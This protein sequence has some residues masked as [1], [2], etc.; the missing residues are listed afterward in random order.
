MKK[1]NPGVLFNARASICSAQKCPPRSG[2]VQSGSKPSDSRVFP[3]LAVPWYAGLKQNAALTPPREVSLE[4][5]GARR[6]LL[7]HLR[8]QGDQALGQRAMDAHQEPAFNMILTLQ[9]FTDS[10]V[11]NLAEADFDVFRM[12]RD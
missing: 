2:L 10:Q 4:R 9:T 11:S 7:E 8:R 5:F 1:E 3:Y 12:H 6:G